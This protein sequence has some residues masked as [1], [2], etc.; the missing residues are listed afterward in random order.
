[1]SKGKRNQHK[2]VHVNKYAK[3]SKAEGAL[4]RIIA[5]QEKE[6]KEKEEAERRAS[7]M[8]FGGTFST[9]STYRPGPIWLHHMNLEYNPQ[10]GSYSLSGSKSHISS[11]I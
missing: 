1:M 5:Q 8:N 3:F 11:T 7:R 10:T 4:A 9:R 6:Q 2:H